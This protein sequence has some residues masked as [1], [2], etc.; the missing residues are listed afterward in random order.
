M[1]SVLNSI[2]KLPRYVKILASNGIDESNAVVLDKKERRRVNSRNYYKLNKELILQKKKVYNE[3]HKDRIKE[4]K[5]NHWQAN[6]EHLKLK[7][8]EYHKRKK[9]KP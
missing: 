2:V 6:K 3:Q 5:K 8:R 7:R 9:V 1:T 4:Y